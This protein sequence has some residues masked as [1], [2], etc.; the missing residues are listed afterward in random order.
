[1]PKLVNFENIKI[2]NNDYLSYESGS[3]EKLLSNN[4][5]LEDIICDNNL[6]IKKNSLI[7]DEHR[8]KITNFVND[9][10]KYDFLSDPVEDCHE[11]LS[12]KKILNNKHNQNLNNIFNNIF[13]IIFGNKKKK[14]LVFVFNEFCACYRYNKRVN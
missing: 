12:L 5:D 7:P 11:V 3:C 13:K 8:E 6:Q 4:L 14:K 9:L 10:L 1:M 2:N